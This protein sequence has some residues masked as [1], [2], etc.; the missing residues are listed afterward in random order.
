MSDLD[1]N[2]ARFV[3]RLRA[4]LE[5]GAR[6]YGESSFRRPIADLLA[7]AMEEAEDICGWSFLAWVRLAR[8]REQV[9]HAEQRAGGTHGS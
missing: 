6:V 5:T 9:A 7:E 4:R 8:L 2:L 3:E 1:A